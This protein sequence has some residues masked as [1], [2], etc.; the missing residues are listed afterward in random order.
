MRI[1]EALKLSTLKQVRLVDKHTNEDWEEAGI[2]VTQSPDGYYY[3]HGENVSKFQNTK[4]LEEN[5][6]LPV[7]PDL[8]GSLLTAVDDRKEREHNLYNALKVSPLELV[9]SVELQNLKDSLKELRAKTAAQFTI[10]REAREIALAASR[11]MIALVNTL[12]EALE[13][14]D[15]GSH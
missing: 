10:I 7:C 11:K 4:L 12:S 6:W 3:H 13:T 2:Y 8:V 15:D 1:Q 9:E 5:C 14:Q